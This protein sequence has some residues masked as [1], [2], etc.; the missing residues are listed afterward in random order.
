MGDFGRG[1][2]L[3]QAVCILEEDVDQ[4]GTLAADD[5]VRLKLLGIGLMH[6][7]ALGFEL[8][9][10]GGRKGGWIIRDLGLSCSS[11]IS[12]INRLISGLSVIESH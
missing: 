9:G 6:G 4:W 10:I 3:A 11:I 8:S 1:P 12:N 5:P 2:L 7:G